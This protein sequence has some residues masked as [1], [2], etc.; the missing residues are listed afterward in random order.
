MKSNIH[1]R[2]TSSYFSNRSGVSKHFFT[3]WRLEWREMGL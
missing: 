2:F 3:K 1:V